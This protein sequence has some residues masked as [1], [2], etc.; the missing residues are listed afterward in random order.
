[1]HLQRNGESSL[2][3]DPAIAGKR[4]EPEQVE[5]LEKVA[6]IFDSR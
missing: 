4:I 3:R 6:D 5:A 2:V 1:M